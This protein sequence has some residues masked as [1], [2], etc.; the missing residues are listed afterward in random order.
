[1]I[2]TNLLVI[3]LLAVGCRAVSTEKPG[4]TAD[5]H[6]VDTVQADTG[7]ETGDT[8][9]N[10]TGSD[11]GSFSIDGEDGVMY[12]TDTMLTLWLNPD[13][14]SGM[15]DAG[16]KEIITVNAL[17]VCG[18]VVMTKA[19]F[20]FSGSDDAGAEWIGEINNV[21]SGVSY[22]YDGHGTFEGFGAY[23]SRT[24]SYDDTEGPQRAVWELTF[25]E[26]IVILKDSNFT[27][28][29]SIRMGGEDGLQPSPTDFFYAD[30]MNPVSWY[31]VDDPSRYPETSLM[32]G[33]EGNELTLA[34]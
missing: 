9:A 6:V 25:T 26:P 17:A 31:G 28:S 22:D 21:V 19:Y 13:S 34:P 33:V 7:A 30:L 10:D 24:V 1:M 12:E 8:A 15:I 2:R 29:L 18:D 5:S 11:C 3:L 16:S 20:F 27:F 4:D 32:G 23:S 14:A